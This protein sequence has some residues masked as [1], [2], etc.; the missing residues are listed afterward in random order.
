[1]LAGNCSAQMIDIHSTILWLFE[2]P[3]VGAM[4]T[5]I[6]IGV[7]VNS[8]FLLFPDDPRI[9]SHDFINRRRRGQCPRQIR[10]RS[11]RNPLSLSLRHWKRALAYKGREEYHFVGMC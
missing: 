7:L 3:L 11:L 8:A 9:L 10:W 1:M 4:P 2:S 6:S 5:A